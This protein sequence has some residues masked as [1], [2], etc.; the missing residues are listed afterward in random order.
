MPKTIVIFCR[1][2]D[3]Q[4]GPF[5]SDYYWNAYIDLLL[6]IKATGAQAYFAT[7]TDT[8]QGNGL[9]TEAYTA[10]GKVPLS[11]FTRETNVHADLVYD[12]G[13]FTATDVPVLNPASVSH[14]ASDK[15]ET[16]AHFKRYQPLSITCTDSEQLRSAV[17]TIPGSLAV[18]KTPTGSGGHGVVIGAK[19]EVLD[20]I[21]PTFPLL[22][23]EFLDT[24]VGIPGFVDGIH[25]LRVKTGNGEVW[26]G[27]LRTPKPGEYRANVAQGGKE[28][29]LYP[30]EIP[31]EA[32]KLALEIDTY[33]SEYPR[34]Y[35]IDMARTA[36]GWKL[37]ELNSKPGLSPVALSPQSR[38]ITETLA[39]YLAKLA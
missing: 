27:T 19:E 16:Y 3:Q 38:H 23:Q 32:K 13:D 39:N 7:N 26:G 5:N 34:Y 14:I 20:R 22:V 1:H 21:T 2:F 24:S 31:E 12:K 30:E 25:D 36:N 9:F 6:A 4:K 11:A 10:D 33:F 8:Y 28:R 17:A 37:I 29:L 35:S 15:T 18:I